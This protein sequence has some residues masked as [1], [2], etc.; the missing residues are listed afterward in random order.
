MNRR[1]FLASSLGSAFV[2][3]E[4]C[5]LRSRGAVVDGDCRLGFDPVPASDADVLSLPEGFRHDV[6][7]SYGDVIG[8][9][10]EGSEALTLGY[11]N[12]FTAFVPIDARDGGRSSERG[13][14]FV[15]HEYNSRLLQHG[16]VDARATTRDQVALEMST[17]G[18][19][20]LEVARG[21]GG[22]RV[23]TD[24]SFARRVS[25]LGPMI[26]LSGPA[27]GSAA[28]HGRSE[29][30]GT[31]SNCSGGVT[32][33]HTVTTCE[34]NYQ[35]AYGYGAPPFE[36]LNGWHRFV[37]G[38][39]TDYGWVVEIDPFGELPPRKRTALGRYAHENCAFTTTGD[40]RLV[41]YSADDHAD[42]CVYKFVSSWKLTGDRQRDW[43][44]ALDEG[45]LYVADFTAGAWRRLQFEDDPALWRGRGFADQGDVLVRARDAAVAVGGTPMDRPECVVVHPR[46]REVFIAFTK[47]IA[48]GDPFGRIAWLREQDAAAEAESFAHGVLA[49]GGAGSESFACPDNLMLDSAGG[50]WMAS[51]ISG[52]NLLVS[53]HERR[54]NNAMFFVETSGENR[55]ASYR[56][57][58]GPRGSEFT[59]PSTTPD[60][61]TLFVSVQHPGELS[62]SLE[63]LDSHWPRGGEQV[64]L[65][66]VV[67]ITRANGQ[68]VTG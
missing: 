1:T 41:A 52:I 47:N 35:Y 62:S 13:L 12:D 48:R 9:A 46:S 57:A 58:N 38:V 54:G 24:S 8:A 61:T 25:A 6:V 59:G 67:A 64:P 14:L 2:L 43:E 50:M 68:R 19:S 36:G 45:V 30:R 40:G 28:A 42:R 20:V 32:P 5:A 37:S 10:A 17:V 29:A 33:W 16:T 55:G 23:I 51:D 60:E 15:N 34:E 18:C 21:D 22:W 44:H 27:R 31:L 49:V 39:P 63:D 7:V 66:S 3:H 4:A 56:F 65:P 11:N 53:P 26:E